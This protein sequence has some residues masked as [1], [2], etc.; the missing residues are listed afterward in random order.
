MQGTFAEEAVSVEP[1]TWECITWL[2][3]PLD[4]EAL[5]QAT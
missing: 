2:H 3:M 4:Y 5:S 1:K